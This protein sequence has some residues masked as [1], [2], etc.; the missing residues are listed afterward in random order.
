MVIGLIAPA[1]REF[2]STAEDAARSLRAAVKANGGSVE[3]DR[4]DELGY[5]RAA[6]G[7]GTAGPIVY[8]HRDYKKPPT[9]VSV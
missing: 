1:P 9:L 3:E 4:V 7:G 8:S 2:E 6:F 5:L